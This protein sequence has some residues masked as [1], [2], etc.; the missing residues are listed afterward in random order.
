MAQVG[1]GQGA[2]RL[3]G[4]GCFP[5]WRCSPPDTRSSGNDKSEARMRLGKAIALLALIGIGVASLGGCVV[6][7]RRDGGV[8]VRPVH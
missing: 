6:H 5:P 7:E 1:G 3:R 8:T 2:G 4:T